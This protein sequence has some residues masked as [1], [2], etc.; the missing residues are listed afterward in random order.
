MRKLKKFIRKIRGRNKAPS[1]QTSKTQLQEFFARFRQ[2]YACVD[3]IRVGGQ[4]DGG[5]LIPDFASK[6]KF[7][8]S[9]GVAQVAS[10]EEAL[11]ELY[12]TFCF[13]CDASVEQAPIQNDKTEF[14]K[15]FLGSYDD[16]NFMTLSSWVAR[17]VDD[18]SSGMLLQMDI[19]GAEYDVLIREDTDFL[20]RF[21]CLV[22]EFHG[23]EKLWDVM[24]FRMIS[25]VFD[26]LLL[27][28]V[29]VH[30]HPNNCCGIYLKDGIGIPRVAEFTFLRRD[31]LGCYEKQRNIILP[32]P[33]DRKNVGK[34]DD[35]VM[36]NIWWHN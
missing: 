5:Y 21:D 18:R 8:F 29:V 16:G 26:K 23:L 22:I 13:L 19:E 25:S 35:L 36:P 6:I 11:Q 20:K 9:P 3:L 30:A 32:H 14:E 17:R 4:G 12:G 1:H 15:M 27:E 2:S 34:N 24:N 10:F 33:L 31:I 28:F 7:C